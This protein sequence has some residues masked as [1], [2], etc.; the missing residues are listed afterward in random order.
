MANAKKC[1]RCGE[2]YT[3]T[4]TVKKKIYVA[5]REWS[6]WKELD[7]CSNCQTKIQEFLDLDSA[8]K[9]VDG[10]DEHKRDH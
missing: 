7:L 5:K 6:E 4:L 9:E 2:F 10:E 3:H 1:D 8:N